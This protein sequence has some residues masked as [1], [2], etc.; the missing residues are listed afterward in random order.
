[1]ADTLP[2][3]P[4]SE[5]TGARP[6]PQVRRPQNVP[7]SAKVRLGSLIDRLR[8]KIL[9]GAYSLAPR[10]YESV[11]KPS[12]GT[13]DMSQIRA[14]LQALE[15]WEFYDV[16]EE[17]VR[18]SGKPEQVAEEIDSVFRLE[19]LP[20]TI[21]S[22]GIEWRLSQPA[23]DAAQAARQLLQ[24]KDLAGPSTQWEKAQGHLARRPPDPENCIKDAV[25]ALEGVARILAGKPADTLGHLIRPL[26][27]QLRMHSALAN[28]VSNLYGYRGDEQAIAHG[29]T[30]ALQ[31]LIAEAELVLHWCAAAMVYLAKKSGRA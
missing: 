20:Y 10:L 18:L 17:L 14:L 29:A 24:A 6:R 4:F 13:G 16:C 31:D 28:A 26:A 1:M 5:R 22:G 8:N 11:G 23:A 30:T 12:Q 9:P 27:V 7:D 15:W 19:G 25:G 21:T 3:T 2:G